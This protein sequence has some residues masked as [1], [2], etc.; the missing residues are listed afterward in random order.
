MKIGIDI[1]PLSS[2]H[3]LQHRV[4][5]TGFYLTNLKDSLV[6]YFPENDYIFFKQGDEIPADI[7]LI[8]IPYFEPFFLTLPKIKKQKLIVTV[9]DLTPLVFADK[10]PAGIKGKIKWEI[11][12]YSLKNSD[13]VITDSISSKKDLEKIAKV[14]ASKID[15]VYL[16]AAQHFISKRNKNEK[17]A[18]K[19]KLPKEFLLYVG[20]ATWNKNL[21]N[22]IKAVGKTEYSLVIAGSAFVNKDYDKSNPWNKDL[23][24][25]QV[26]A[27]VNEKILPIGFISDEDLVEIYNLATASLMPS[28]YEGFGLPILEA[29]QSGCPVITSKE[30]SLEEVADS[31]AYFVDP[32]DIDSIQKG[33]DEV[34]KDKDLREALSKK[35]LH[36]AGKFTWQQTARKTNE[37]YKK[38][39][40]G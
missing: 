9:H 32:Y 21:P 36:Q 11:Q 25:S 31:A 23:Y 14:Q 19:Y 37:V 2:G 18:K 34:M 13:Y 27:S 22:L 17:I 33:I 10:F 39:I 5:G 8:H 26:L 40:N 29:M 3:Y 30:G 15:V 35:G 4:R 24:E 16:A 20:D 28:F 1:S 6:K 38:V 12:K 7:D